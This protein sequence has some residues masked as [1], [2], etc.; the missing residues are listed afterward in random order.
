MIQDRCP[1]CN[2]SLPATARYCPA[3]GIP[4]SPDAPVRRRH[5]EPSAW[6]QYLDAAWD[7]FASTR[8]ATVL[9]ILIAVAAIGGSLVEQES[10]YQDWRPPE[11]YYPARYGEFLGRFLMATGL[12]HTYTSWWFLSLVY[13]LVISLIV[14]SLQRLVPLH[15]AL[16]HPTVEKHPG[17]LRRQ[18]VQARL[19]G[20]GEDP[21]ATLA[22]AL[23]RRGFRVWREGRGLHADRGRLGR[24][25]PYII[26]IGLIIAA[27]AATAKVIPGW[28][29][30]EDLRVENGQTVALPGTYL[31]IRNNRFV[32]ETYPNGM[33]RLFQTQ[34]TLLENGVEVLHHNI[35]VNRP[36][37]YGPWWGPW[38]IYQASFRE[39]PGIAHARLVKGDQ[40]LGELDLDLKSPALEYSVN[41]DVR[42]I[43]E[44][45]FHDFHVDPETGQPANKSRE[46][47]N[48]VFLLRFVGPDGRELGRQAL[49]VA[50]D[51]EQQEAKSVVDGPYAVEQT[52]LTTRWYTG[53]RAHK[54][55]T[56]PYMYGG[57]VVVLLGMYITF[58]VFH[59]QVWALDLG[60]EVLMGARTN[61]NRWGMQQELRQVVAGLGGEVTTGMALG[62]S[63]RTN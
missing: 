48:P 5:D 9:I 29:V 61:K 47:V 38:E 23:R 35:E 16:Q 42:V 30:T 11:L 26:H 19:P 51:L 1:D 7:F 41:S 4:V 62:H 52:G 39:E 40:V 34:A 8:V 13:L 37:V 58:F 28:D 32:L 44:R 6:T 33:P 2:S 12:T 20:G 53:L 25:G 63:N 43:V 46:I 50:V 24:Y 27:F 36:L 18:P 22:V 3:C 55:L 59:R 21:L 49:N 17:F 54:D 14:C 10:L 60:D 31:A 57:L 15:R 56:V 45:Y